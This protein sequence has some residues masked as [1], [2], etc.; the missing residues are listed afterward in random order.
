MLPLASLN[1]RQSDFFGVSSTVPTASYGVSLNPLSLSVRPA[2]LN[3]LTDLVEVLSDSFYPRTGLMRWFFPILRM[4][5]YE[6]LRYRLRS[7][8]SDYICL[9]AMLETAGGDKPTL[10][11]TVELSLRSTNP[12]QFRSLPY[13]YLSNLAVR[14][15]SRRQGVAKKLLDTCETIARDRGFQD[16]YLHVMEDNHQA[17]QLYANAGYQAKQPDSFWHCWGLRY[18]RKLLLHKWLSHLPK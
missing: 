15:S 12:F 5:V 10:A 17:R 14:S 7:S 11:G 4:G 18:P 2:Q 6:D 1:C 13:P 3:D 8:P 9:V 16:L